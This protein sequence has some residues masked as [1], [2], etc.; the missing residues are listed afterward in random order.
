MNLSLNLFS[1]S[2]VVLVTKN[3]FKRTQKTHD[4]SQLIKSIDYVFE[5][6]NQGLE[7]Q[8]TGVG[9]GIK[10]HDYIILKCESELSYYQIQEIDY[11]ADPPDMWMALLKKVR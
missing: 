10:S 8:M 7:G 2:P 11:Y 6:L 3:E 1:W 5:P 4:Y 9:K